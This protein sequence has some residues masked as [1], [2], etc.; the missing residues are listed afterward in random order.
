MAMQFGI[1]G[2]PL[3]HSFSPAWFADKFRK[4]GI[5]AQYHAFPL[6]DIAIFP[7]FRKNQT[8]LRGLNVT[9]PYK[10]SVIRYLDELDPVAEKVGAVNCIAFINGRLKGYNTDVIGF[11]T[12]LR[13]LLRPWHKQALV[14]GSGGAAKAVTY[15]LAEMRIPFKVASRKPRLDDQFV[16]TDYE[17]LTDELLQQYNIVVNATPIGMY[18]DVDSYPPLPYS[19][20]GEKH[21]L[22]DL[23]YN[24]A[25]TKFLSLG[26][27]NGAAICNGHQML[28]LQAEAS[29]E[30]WSRYCL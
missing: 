2:Y 26:K 14:L 13:Q 7:E 1:L 19:A 24:P 27:E 9:I 20:I 25:E 8:E 4:L 28:V 12:S 6:P 18:P 11:R 30:I 5:D 3:T 21:L 10:E 22:Y 29:W 15:V 16:T 17:L 23:I